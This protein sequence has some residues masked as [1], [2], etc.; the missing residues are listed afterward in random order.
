MPLIP[1]V[2]CP[3]PVIAHGIP[4]RSDV[5]VGIESIPNRL[6]PS[7]IVRQSGNSVLIQISDGVV[8]NVVICG[9]PWSQRTAAPILIDDP[10]A[11]AA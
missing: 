2:R 7:S 4:F 6:V 11:I 5:A 1:F 9:H 8:M 3:N 10:Y